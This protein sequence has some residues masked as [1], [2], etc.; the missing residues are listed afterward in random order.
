ML[1]GVVLGLFHCLIEEVA[2][3]VPCLGD[4]AVNGAVVLP[5]QG[6]DDARVDDLGAVALEGRHA[7]DQEEH[8][9]QPVEGNPAGDEV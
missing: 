2:G 6:Q 9:A 4:G 3:L 7:P 1:C 5:E 8:L